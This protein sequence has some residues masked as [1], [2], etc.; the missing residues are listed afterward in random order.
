MIWHFIFLRHS[1]GFWTLN[2]IPRYKNVL[3]LAMKLGRFRDGKNLG[4]CFYGFLSF[5]SEIQ[6]KKGLVWLSLEI[7]IK[8]RLITFKQTHR[9]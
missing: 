8:H 4:K 5:F 9:Q 7:K 2:A 6:N 1:V 3:I